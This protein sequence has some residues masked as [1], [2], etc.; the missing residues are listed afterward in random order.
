MHFA[1]IVLTENG[2]EGEISE[3]LAPHYEQ[4]WDWYQ[5]GGRWTGFF[6]GYKPEDDPTNIETCNLCAGT[7]TRKDMK[8]ENGCN[9]CQGKGKRV[10]WPTEWETRPGDTI[11]TSKLTEENIK[12]AY[13]V[14]D[15]TGWHGGERYIPW[16]DGMKGKFQRMPKPPVDW[17]KK[18]RCATIVDCHN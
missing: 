10:K 12:K 11:E 6:D 3:A 17:A 5:V 1:V 14:V 4:E 18:H 7:G 2:T 13:A 8:V 9:G 15:R 16:G